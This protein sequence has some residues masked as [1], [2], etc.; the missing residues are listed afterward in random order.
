MAEVVGPCIRSVY[1]T[2]YSQ[3]NIEKVESR[4]EFSD[5]VLDSFRRNGKANVLRWV[6]SKEDHKD[7]GHHYHMA[8]KLDRKK[9]GYQSGKIWIKSFALRY[10]FQTSYQITTKLGNM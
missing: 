5:T 6:C 4:L 1:L 9:G 8:I 10:T 3:A 2:A 7:R